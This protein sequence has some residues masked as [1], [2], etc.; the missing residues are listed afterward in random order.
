MKHKIYTLWDSKDG[1]RKISCACLVEVSLNTLF[2]KFYFLNFLLYNKSHF[3][4][5]EL[6]INVVWPSFKKYI[7]VIW[8]CFYFE[9]EGK[10]IKRQVKQYFSH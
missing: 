5:E 4:V 1:A 6:D 9:V 7:N 8:P 2:Q 3:L 10:S